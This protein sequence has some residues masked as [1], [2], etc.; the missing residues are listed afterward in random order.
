MRYFLAFV[1]CL[2]LIP[3]N[4]F[5]LTSNTHYADL[6]DSSSQYFSITD[7]S[8]T[9][10]DLSTTSTICL[11]VNFENRQNE[12]KFV[13]K[14]LGTGNQ[15]SFSFSAPLTNT[16]QWEIYGNGG[17]ST[18]VYTASVTW[19]SSNGTW[20]F[21]CMS[22]NGTSV[23]FYV[24]GTQQGTT[25]TMGG[26]AIFNG[27]AAF[28]I[29]GVSAFTAYMDGQIDDVRVWTRVLSDGD[30]SSLHSDP[31]NFANGANLVGHWVFDN[32]AN[33]S[34]GSGNNLTNNNAATFVAV[35]SAPYTCAA[36]SVS[37]TPPGV[38]FF[39]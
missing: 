13:S 5:G 28:E 4:L 16:L 30:I 36:G 27:T 29:G 3:S 22:Q 6:E 31:C 1:L 19:A 10:L 14:M 37:T 15:R 9:G 2:L 38:I 21:L 39:E 18:E 33:D 35:T 11:W 8:Q 34:S 32:N 24:N 25:Q 26:S 17:F 12:E 7:A 20:Y 23:K